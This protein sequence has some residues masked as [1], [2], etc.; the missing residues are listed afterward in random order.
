MPTD[1]VEG[2]RRLAARQ[3]RRALVVVVSN[4]GDADGGELP[5]AVQLLTR[6]HLVVHASL[7]ETALDRVLEDPVQDL[8]GAL[9]TSSAHALLEGRAAAHDALRRRGVKPLDV[10]P[11][12]LPGALVDRYL[13]IKRARVL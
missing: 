12:E 11:S 5:Q 6:R 10:T 9:R 1:Y 13:A 3:R 4:L 7:R 2:A 8:A